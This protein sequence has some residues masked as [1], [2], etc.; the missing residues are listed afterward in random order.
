MIFKPGGQVLDDEL[1]SLP[2]LLSLGQEFAYSCVWRSG[3][4]ADNS[5][6]NAAVEM[7]WKQHLGLS[8]EIRD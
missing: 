5:W 3:I 7:R 6:D 1:L 8:S 4:W 2:A